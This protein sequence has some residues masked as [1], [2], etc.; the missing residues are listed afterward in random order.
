[1]LVGFFLCLTY[2]HRIYD[3]LSQKLFGDI[4]NIMYLYYVINDKH[5]D[6]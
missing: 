4:K 1:M 5:Y 2:S 6:E 3:T